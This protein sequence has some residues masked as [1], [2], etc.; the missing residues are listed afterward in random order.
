[1]DFIVVRIR[2][3]GPD[4][5]EDLPVEIGAVYIK[6]PTKFYYTKCRPPWSV[7]GKEVEELKRE[8]ITWLDDKGIPTVRQALG[9]FTSWRL[10]LLGNVRL[11]GSN[12]N[13]DFD[14]LENVAKKYHQSLGFFGDSQYLGSWFRFSLE[15]R[16]MPEPDILRGANLTAAIF[17][18]AGLPAEPE[19]HNM[20]VSAKMEA[21][22][23]VRLTGNTLFLEFERYP[24]PA[25][26]K[27]TTRAIDL[28]RGLEE[29]RKKV[30]MT[31]ISRS[32]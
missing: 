28:L 27:D 32:Y 9:G 1:M 6:D 15:L 31:T 12:V 8:G 29:N 19:P 17:K 4:L 11:A 2:T 5:A 30:Q 14:F 25:Y 16:G 21:E 24:L 3:T 23:F 26:L 20:L 10:G 18:Y 7:E 22:A 13:S